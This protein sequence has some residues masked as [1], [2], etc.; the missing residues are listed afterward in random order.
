MH[1]EVIL[2]NVVEVEVYLRMAV[3]LKHVVHFSKI[4]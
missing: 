1:A 4:N 2:V 3:R